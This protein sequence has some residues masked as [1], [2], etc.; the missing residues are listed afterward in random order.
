MG[1]LGRSETR[2]IYLLP[3]AARSMQVGAVIGS[4]ERTMAKGVRL[5]LLGWRTRGL[6]GAA[7]SSVNYDPTEPRVGRTSAAHEKAPLRFRASGAW[8]RSR[9]SSLLGFR[10]AYFFF[11]VAR[12]SSIAA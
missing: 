11:A 9:A 4:G 8:G 3:G 12:F 1:A 2:R 6:S 10:I 5:R 7:W